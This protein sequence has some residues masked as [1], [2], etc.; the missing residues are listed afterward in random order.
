MSLFV[1]GI[2][3]SGRDSSHFVKVFS[4]SNALIL[5]LHHPM[6][7]VVACLRTHTPLDASNGLADYQFGCTKIL[8]SLEMNYLYCVYSS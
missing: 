1:S 7:R 2:M 3:A 6:H 8:K 4:S 5:V